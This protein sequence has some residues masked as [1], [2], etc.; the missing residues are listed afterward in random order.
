MSST[1]LQRFLLQPHGCVSL[2]TLLLIRNSSLY[3]LLT[4]FQIPIL[5]LLVHLHSKGG[6][7]RRVLGLIRL[8]QQPALNVH[9][10]LAIR[11]AHIEAVKKKFMLRLVGDLKEIKKS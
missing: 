3:F 1:Q 8:I 5:E 7:E 4:L 2:G 11:F 6:D 9:N 10:P